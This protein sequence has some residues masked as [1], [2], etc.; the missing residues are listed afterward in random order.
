MSA[1]KEMITHTKNLQKT[2]E[3][4]DTSSHRD[5]VIEEVNNLLN[6]REQLI[7]KITKPTSNEEQRLSEELLHINKD[8]QQKMDL[9]LKGLKNDMHVHTLQRKSNHSY[10]NPYNHIQVAD[11]MF[12]DRKK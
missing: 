10:T 5:Q 8:V 1:L 11:G 4:S 7:P 12:V 9:F 2:L 6:K 3:E